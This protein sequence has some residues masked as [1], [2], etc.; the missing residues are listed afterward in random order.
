VVVVCLVGSG[1]CDELVTRSEE[2]YQV[3]VP[4]CVC[5]SPPPIVCHVET[6]R[7]RQ[8]RPVLYCYTTEKECFFLMKN[9]LY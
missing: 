6:S 4:N 1:V 3:C 5:V 8:P 7:V 9:S 2:S